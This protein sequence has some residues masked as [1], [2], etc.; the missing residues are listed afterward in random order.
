M[1]PIEAGGR[2]IASI[3][4]SA[5]MPANS[6]LLARCVNFIHELSCVVH[7]GT[8]KSDALAIMLGFTGGRRIC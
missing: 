3:A 6:G 7:Q 1:Q 5:T 2:R 4:P 8:V